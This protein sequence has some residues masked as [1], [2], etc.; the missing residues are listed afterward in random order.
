M[1]KAS[2]L[3]K[4]PKKSRKKLYTGLGLLIT[5]FLSIVFVFVTI[6]GQ[7]TGNYLI[8]LTKDAREKGISISEDNEFNKDESILKIQPLTFTEDMIASFDYE[9]I[10][11]TNGQYFETDGSKQHYIA[12]TFY[13]RNLGKE[14]V[15]LEYNIV[16]MDDYKNL[17]SGTAVWVK[18][19]SYKGDQQ[20]G[21]PFE[22]IY[23]KAY[24]NKNEIARVKL[25]SFKPNDV[26]KFTM[27]IWLNGEGENITTSA[28]MLGGALKLEWVFRITDGDNN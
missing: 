3:F 17:A 16:V 5:G 13:I 10:E 23:S 8:T 27:I 20:I 4:Q 24:T 18:R 1:M 21:E 28:D 22:T 14:V 25:A 15:N 9:A 19:T 26:Y 7:Y 6:Y 12:Y 11:S 2:D